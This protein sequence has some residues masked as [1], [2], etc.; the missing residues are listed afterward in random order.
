[1]IPRNVVQQEQRKAPAGVDVTAI[2]DRVLARHRQTPYANVT[3]AFIAACRNAATEAAPATLTV[4]ELFA[5]AK[6]ELW[7]RVAAGDLSPK[8]LAEDLSMLDFA[9]K[10]VNGEEIRR[11]RALG[12]AWPGQQL[13]GRGGAE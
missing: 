8:R 6:V 9:G 5:Q 1:M 3:G 2:R 12:D 7:C 11:L 4:T 13:L 10:R